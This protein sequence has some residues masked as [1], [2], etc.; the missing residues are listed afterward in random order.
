[1]RIT[2]VFVF[3]LVAMAATSINSPDRAAAQTGV[4]DLACCRAANAECMRFC[5]ASGR[6]KTC[7]ADCQSMNAG[8]RS[9]GT[10]DWRTR[11]P[12]VCKNVAKIPASAARRAFCNAQNARC[13]GPGCTANPEPLGIKSCQEVECGG[14]LVKCLE[15]G[16]Y[17]WKAGPQCHGK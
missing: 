2:K 15:T 1:M 8:C 14:R 10:Y 7:L 3:L 5:E 4:A 16:C 11:P 9:K 17:R 13:R 6:G 12:T